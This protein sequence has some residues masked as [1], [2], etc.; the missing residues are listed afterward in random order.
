[1][2]TSGSTGSPKLVRLSRGNLRRQRHGDRRVSRHRRNRQ[3]RNDTADVVLLRPFGDPQPPAARRRAHPHRPL[4]RRRRVL[5]AVPPAPRHVVR[6]RALHLRPARADRLRRHRPA[7]PALRH[8]GRRPDAARTRAPLRRTRRRAAAGELFVMYGATEAT[9][10][11]AYLPP[12]LAAVAARRDRPPDPRRLVHARAARRMVRRRRGRAGL[13]RPER[14]DG[15]RATGPAD[16][17]LGKTVDDAAHRRR[18][19]PRPR[20]AVRGDRP[21][22]PLRQAVRPAHR[23]AAGRGRAERRG[24]DGLLHRRRRAAGGRRGG[25]R[26]PC[27]AT[28]HGAGLRP[29]RGRRS[30]DHHGRTAAAAVG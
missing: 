13:P 5:G 30:G 28:H 19:P 27:R 18:R 14:D 24:R 21:Q 7:R 29:S 3:G 9:A 25:H 8:P 15:L 6:R 12:E 1:M 4:G 2:S 22:Q 10:R 11:M 20:R 17:A 26:R 16:L 23:S